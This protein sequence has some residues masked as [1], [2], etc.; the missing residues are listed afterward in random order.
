MN[1]VLIDVIT[2]I[3]IA[4]IFLLTLHFV[5]IHLTLNGHGHEHEHKQ[6]I[7]QIFVFMFVPLFEAHQI[8]T[9]IYIYI[10]I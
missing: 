3:L 9:N 1:C 2:Y 8:I 5:C 10:Y 6:L 4:V 7:K